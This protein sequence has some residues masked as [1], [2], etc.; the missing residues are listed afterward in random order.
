MIARDLKCSL[1]VFKNKKQERIL[2]ICILKMASHRKKMLDNYEN[3]TFFLCISDRYNISAIN[4]ADTRLT[5]I[6]NHRIH[7]SQNPRNTDWR[8][9]I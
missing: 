2:Y 4:S 5:R 6:P 3:L 9:R 1:A 7:N 8:G